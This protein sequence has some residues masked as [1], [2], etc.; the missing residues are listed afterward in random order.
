MI[1]IGCREE[2]GERIYYVRDNGV[3]FNMQYA[4]KLFGV[5]QQLHRTEDYEGAGLGL[6]TVQRIIQRHGGQV[7]AEGEVDKGATFYFTLDEGCMP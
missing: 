2:G 7:W 1:E 6:A 5:F 3:A 4:D